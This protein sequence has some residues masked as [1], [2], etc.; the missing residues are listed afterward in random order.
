MNGSLAAMIMTSQKDY[1]K[2]TED[3]EAVRLSADHLTYVGQPM[4]S[5]HSIDR[6][7]LA[8]L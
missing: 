8:F 1:S 2:D 7:R 5:G 4:V 3:I 6:R